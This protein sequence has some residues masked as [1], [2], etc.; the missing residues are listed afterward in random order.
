MG[1]L[2]TGSVT[3]IQRFNSALGAN[4]HFHTLFLDGVYTFPV[5]RAPVFHPTPAPTDEDVARVAAAVFRR[6]EARL[7]EREPG[8][9][10]R[11]FVEGAPVLVAMAEASVGGVVATGPRR[12]R[13]IVRVRS[14]GADLD[15]F[16][17]GR[18]K[19]IQNTVLR[20]LG[21]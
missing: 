6:V 20:S 19:K 7:A 21:R 4:P 12:G 11:R 16:V 18:G 14:A 1:A 3:V 9:V 8:A 2:K 5:G 15:A 17:M 10:Q 13:H